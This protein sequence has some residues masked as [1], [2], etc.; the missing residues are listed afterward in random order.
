MLPENTVIFFGHLCTDGF[1]EQS[2]QLNKAQ[3]EFDRKETG[4]R[5]QGY[6]ARL[7][8]LYR[9]Q[10]IARGQVILDAIKT[11]HQRFGLASDDHL[12]QE[13]KALAGSM[14]ET[15][16]KNLRV[17]YGQHLEPFGISPVRDPLEYQAPMTYAGVLNAIGLH[18]W[19]VQN[20]PMP[21]QTDPALI[22]NI[23]APV[24]AIQTG[25]NAIANVAMNWTGENVATVAKAL[26]EFKSLLATAP[27]ID[28]Q[29]RA[30]LLEDVENASKE[31]ESANPEAWRLTRWLGG[32]GTAVQTVGALQAAWE[33]VKVGLRA[34]GL[35]F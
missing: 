3:R 12:T 17:A 8:Q 31:L 32:V 11:I 4:P 14:L 9:D 29:L 26:A 25:A 13:L 20:V 23:H 7:A 5:G 1:A 19:E 28:V 15:Q 18:L 22:F 10:L 21:K 24:G 30:D 33:A 16:T 2:R 6:A 27:D 35:P 34:L